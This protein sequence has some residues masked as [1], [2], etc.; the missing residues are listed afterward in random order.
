MKSK[1]L[2]LFILLTVQQAYSQIGTGS[3]LIGGSLQ[4]QSMERFNTQELRILPN[5]QYFISDNIS[6]GGNL[7]F[8][9]ERNNLGQD[10]Y[11]RTNTFVFGPE[12]RYYIELG[13]NV[14]FYGAASLGFGFGGSTFIDGNDR[15]DTEDTSTFNFGVNPGIL[16]TPGSKVGFN[17]E[18][19]LIS[20]GRNSSTPAGANTSTV[21][22]GFTFGTNTFTPTFGL[23]YIIGN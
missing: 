9:T 15:T 21:F 7:G 1:L 6:I 23:Y 17:F 11:T 19:N 12:A 2:V 10:T 16:F 13:E 18:L 4:F 3:T 5:V 20:F 8:V 14:H 22:N